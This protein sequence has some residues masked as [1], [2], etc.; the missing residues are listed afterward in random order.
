MLGCASRVT[1]PSRRERR[2]LM[3]HDV[4]FL[5]IASAT[6]DHPGIIYCGKTARS[7][8]EIIRG[9]ILI[10]EVLTPEELH[11]QVEFL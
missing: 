5:R 9:L 4:D 2:A 8:G 3:T 11:G 10:Y 1:Q 6:R 7:V